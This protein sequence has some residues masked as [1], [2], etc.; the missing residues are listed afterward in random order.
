MNAF[1]FPAAIVATLIASSAYA[2]TVTVNIKTFMFMP[3]TVTVP[4]GSTITWVNQDEIP[5]SVIEKGKSFRSPALDTNDH[6]SRVFDTPGTYEYF[7]GLH[8][9]MV[10]RVIVTAAAKPV[11]KAG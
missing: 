10:A 11:K 3:M 7:C 8:P 9:N 6:F 5:H 2:D 1:L 4:A